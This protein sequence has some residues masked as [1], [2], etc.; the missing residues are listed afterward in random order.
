MGTG[1]LGLL[2]KFGIPLAE[3]LLLNH[4]EKAETLAAVVEAVNNLSNSV[5]MGEALLDA[6]EK[7][8]ENIIK[9][10]FDVLVGAGNAVNT[11]AGILI[12]LM[13]KEKE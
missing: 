6:N 13:F 10:L 2:L 9:G 4:E 1:E 7:E 3:S 11:L 5:A 8:T 12:N